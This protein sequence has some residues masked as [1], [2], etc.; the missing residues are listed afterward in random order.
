MTKLEKLFA[1][2]IITLS[3]GVGTMLGSTIVIT[4]NNLDLG[5]GVGG[6]LSIIAA[7]LYV[8]CLG[9]ERKTRTKDDG[10]K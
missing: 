5:L 8:Y 10:S 3:V 6:V 7:S 2:A 4:T 1:T 9:R